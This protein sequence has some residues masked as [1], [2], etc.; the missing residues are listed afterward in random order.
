MTRSIVET[1]PKDLSRRFRVCVCVCV[2][3]CV[4]RFAS[5]V[6][7]PMLVLCL[8]LCSVASLLFFLLA[9]PIMAKASSEWTLWKLMSKFDLTHLYPQFSG[10]GWL[11]ADT[12]A[13]AAGHNPNL[14][15][16]DRL[17]RYV[18]RP[19]LQLPDGQES[20]QEHTKD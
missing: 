16:Q 11:T 10:R 1:V 18:K 3:V 15:Q 4:Q 8:L 9:L 19:L 13:F 7:A 14:V 2:C 5:F 20:L 6:S 12:F 17:S